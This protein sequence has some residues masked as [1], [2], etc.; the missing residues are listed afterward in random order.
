MLSFSPDELAQ[1]ARLL[2]AQIP[3]SY[4][5]QIHPSSSAVGGGS[6]PGAVL[7]TFV[8]AL[9]PGELGAEGLAL[10]L[11]L[12]EPSI[13]VRVQDG[14]VLFDPRTLPRN[15]YEAIGQALQE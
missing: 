7:P 1:Q 10:R 3:S 8:V 4:Q 9:Q 12:G 13:V 6:F 5:V 2:A 11:R 15:S 14:Q